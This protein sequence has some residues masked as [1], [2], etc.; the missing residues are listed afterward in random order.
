LH[1]LDRVLQ[2]DLDELVGALAE[3]ERSRLL[4]SAEE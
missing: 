3:D 1:K 4:K 2:G